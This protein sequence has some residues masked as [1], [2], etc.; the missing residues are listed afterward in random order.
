M[1]TFRGLILGSILA[2]SAAAAGLAAQTGSLDCETL[3]F[4]EDCDVSS[5]MQTDRVSVMPGINERV[6]DSFEMADEYD[7]HMPVG[8]SDTL[9]VS[10]AAQVAQVPLPDHFSDARFY[11]MT[12][13]YALCF[14]IVAEL[15]K[16]WQ[17]RGIDASED[18]EEE[19]KT[20]VNTEP[21]FTGGKQSTE[22][23]VVDN[24]P[25]FDLGGSADFD[26][27]AEAVRS[28]DESRCLQIVK[29]RHAARKE[30]ACGCTALHIAAQC[31]SSAMAKILIEHGAKVNARTAWDETPLHIAAREG[32]AEVCQ[33]LLEHGA[34][35]NAADANGQTPVLA[36][37][38]AGKEAA[39]EMLLAKDAGVHGTAD[40]ELPPLLNSLLF[41]RMFIGATPK[42]VFETDAVDTVEEDGF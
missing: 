24:A 23:P 38:L 34:E 32:S 16:R 31:G 6:S 25:I 21:F 12:L 35:V 17:S 30:D 42:E 3:Q 28:Q 29:A 10:L 33:L 8:S 13:T 7:A 39:C 19:K 40:S 26:A 27:L 5:L 1:A 14:A 9:K 15:F 36:A 4:G 22:K 37:A 41:R 18:E 20:P 2:C 11:I